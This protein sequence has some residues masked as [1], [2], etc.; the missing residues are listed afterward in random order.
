[1]PIEG[2]INSLYLD[3]EQ[4]KT[5]FPRTKTKAISDENGVGLDATLSKIQN[6][7]SNKATET[8]V[9][10]KIAEAQL[11]GGDVEVDL[12]GFATKDDIS[13][14]ATKNELN[15][16]DFPVDSVNGKTGAVTLNAADIDAAPA[17]F[18]NHAF[19]SNGTCTN[20][21]LVDITNQYGD[22]NK[23][24]IISTSN[25]TTLTNTPSGNGFP[26]SGYFIGNRIV[27][28]Y[29][30]NRVVVMVY[31]A[32]PVQGRIWINHYNASTWDGWN[33]INVDGRVGSDNY[34]DTLPAIRPAGS[35]FYKKV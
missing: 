12:T 33:C 2:T 3:Y 28:W 25:V 22:N 34:G 5:L 15:S 29:Q 20:F 13:T 30:K 4:T 1:M 31:E 7:L 6:D 19:P 10:N 35:I 11:G 26:S 16:I 32:Y 27:N 17:A 21:L 18:I 23:P 9:T 14:L 8:F 24:Q